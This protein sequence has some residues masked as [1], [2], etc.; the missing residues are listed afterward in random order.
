MRKTLMMAL[1]TAGVFSIAAPLSAHHSPASWDITKRTNITG[2][3]KDAY[4]RNPHGH[5]TLLVKDAKG[6]VTEWQIEAS[7]ANLLRR[8]GWEFSKIK[9]GLNATFIGH[10][11]KTEP[12]ALYLR[13]VRFE[14][15]TGF[16]DKEGNDK[17]LD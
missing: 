11:N 10:P 12:R 9:P 5:I 13:E 3:V 16:G 7:A 1:A 2:E 4:F 8:R 17:A 14:D 15:G 6:R